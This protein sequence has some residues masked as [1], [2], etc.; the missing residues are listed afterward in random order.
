MANNVTPEL[1]ARETEA[2]E[3]RARLSK[4]LETLTRPETQEAVKTEVLGHVQ[5][6][7]DELMKQADHYKDELVQKADEYKGELLNRAETYKCEIMERAEQYKSEFLGRADEY[8]NEALH[9]AEAYKDEALQR[10]RDA[11]RETVRNAVDNLKARALNNPMAVA[12]IGAGVGWRLYKHPPITILL[13]GAGAA[14]LMR[15]PG[16]SEQ[17][18]PLGSVFT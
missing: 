16:R 12:L 4:T 9:R 6:Y 5:S 1:E 11:G 8:K 3:A 13:V 18:D 17:D 14:L 2:E 7:R 10:A 15:A